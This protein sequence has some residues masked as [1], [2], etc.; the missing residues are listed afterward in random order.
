MDTEVI[1]EKI[2]GLVEE[3]NC[4]GIVVIQ[5]EDKTSILVSGDDKAISECVISFIETNRINGSGLSVLAAYCLAKA[6]GF[7]DFRDVSKFTDYITNCAQMYAQ[8][9]GDKT[10]S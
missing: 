4:D 5:K 9:Q 1:I 10:F 3:N 2:K 7:Y 6:N 8:M